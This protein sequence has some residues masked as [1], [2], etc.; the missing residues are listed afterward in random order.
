ME[1]T[2]ESERVSCAC[3]S[4]CVLVMALKPH[5]SSC[6]HFFSHD[7]FFFLFTTSQY[8]F[9]L[10]EGRLRR[11]VAVC[12]VEKIASTPR[13]VSTPHVNSEESSL[14]SPF[15]VEGG[16]RERERGNVGIETG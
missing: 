12:G 9:P 2:Q 4:V 11:K 6:R 7:I 5:L 1:T 10:L 3:V 13:P 8:F 16:E 15:P 14:T